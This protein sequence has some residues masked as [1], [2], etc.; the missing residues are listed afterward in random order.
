VKTYA[1][2]ADH[3]RGSSLSLSLVGDP[4][5]F[6]AIRR[7]DPATHEADARVSPRAS[8]ALIVLSSLGLW[9]LIWFALSYLI[10]NWP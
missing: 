9:A 8:L 4:A 3:Q 5:V 1:A 7:D 10:S 6:G 2:S